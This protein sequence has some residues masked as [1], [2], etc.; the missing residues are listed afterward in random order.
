MGLTPPAVG[1]GQAG[2]VARGPAHRNGQFRFSSRKDGRAPAGREQ[3]TG[4][5]WFVTVSLTLAVEGRRGLREREQAPGG[6]RRSLWVA[7][8]PSGS[9][10]WGRREER[11]F[12]I[13]LEVE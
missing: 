13:S 2:W 7:R 12:R 6:Q 11:V 1:E 8:W 9:R 4:V 3:R 10:S 5:I